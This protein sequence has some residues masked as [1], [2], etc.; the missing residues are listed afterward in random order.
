MPKRNQ[1]SKFIR[2]LK[3]KIEKEKSMGP[4]HFLYRRADYIPIG[5]RPEDFLEEKLINNDATILYN[6]KSLDKLKKCLWDGIG[7]KIRPNA[8]RILFKYTPLSGYN[9]EMILKKKREEYKEYINMNKEEKFK[10]ENDATILETIKLIRKDVL[11]TLP[12]SHVFRNT[13]IQNALVRMLFIYAIRFFYKTSI[14]L[15]L[16]RFERYN[17]SYICNICC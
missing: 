12:E 13:T 15:L 4:I 5:P 6:F 11:R 9:E 8:W 2:N 10:A 3:A 17:G 14:K 16:T 1:K 7:P